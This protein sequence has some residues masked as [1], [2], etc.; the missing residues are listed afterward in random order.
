MRRWA[1]INVLL[2]LIVALLAIQIVSTWARSLPPLEEHARQ[3][4]P[5]VS[6]THLTLPTILR[7]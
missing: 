1:I 4:P 5:A 6:Y 3:P 2:G 7:V